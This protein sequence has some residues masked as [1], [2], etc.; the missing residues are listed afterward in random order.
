MGSGTKVEELTGEAR[1]KI[2]EQLPEFLLKQRWFGAKAR[3]IRSAL[4]LDVVA[5]GAAALLVIGVEYEEGMAERYA[6]P[7]K[8]EGAADGCGLQDA[9]GDGEFLAT[10]LECV[11]GE[12]EFRGER[13]SLRGVQTKRFREF[14][15]ASMGEARLIQGEQSNSSVIYGDKLILKFIRRMEEGE[16]PDLE[17]GRFLSE[18]TK[19]PHIAKVAGYLEYRSNDGGC[20]TQG[21]LQEFVANEGDAWGHTQQILG[22][23]YRRGDDVLD[24]HLL[25]EMGLLGR[26]TAEV[27]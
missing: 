17:I 23:A 22:E 26:R 4:V 10:L 21:I 14:D 19:Y 6:V 9:M 2:V 24:R 27:Q 7:V 11:K 12:R 3:K 1:R 18:R 5:M 8:R 20:V 16:N 13:G 15:S 25:D